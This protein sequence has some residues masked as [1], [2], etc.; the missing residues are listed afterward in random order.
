MGRENVIVLA[1]HQQQI[2]A[3]FV[4]VK[5]H[6]I[7]LSFIHAFAQAAS[8]LSIKNV[9]LIINVYVTQTTTLF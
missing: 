7:A 1:F 2:S 5:E 6:R 8:N 9:S 4:G 3:E